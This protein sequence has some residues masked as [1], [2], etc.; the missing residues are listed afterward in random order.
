[1][2]QAVVH[3]VLRRESRSLL[4]YLREVPP[5]SGLSEQHTQ[6]RLQEIGNTELAELELL[7]KLFQKHFHDMPHLGAYPD[8]TPYNDSALHFMLPLIVHEQKNLLAGLE[9]DRVAI[10]EHEIGNAID[11]LIALKSRNLSELESLHTL[12][13]TFRSTPV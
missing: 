12:P 9:R 1:M 6:A 10:G 4:Q 11:H 13:H 2:S 7:G 3:A 8:F 5:W